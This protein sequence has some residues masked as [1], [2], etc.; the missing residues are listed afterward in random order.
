MAA[1]PPGGASYACPA[2]SAGPGV[3]AAVAVHPGWYATPVPSADAGGDVGVGRR[4]GHRVRGLP[5]AGSLGRG[6]G[7]GRGVPGVVCGAR[8]GC[9][10]SGHRAGSRHLRRPRRRRSRRHW[11]W[12]ARPFRRRPRPRPG[13]ARLR[14]PGPGLPSLTRTLRCRR[15]GRRRRPGRAG[16]RWSR[17]W[18]GGRRPPG[19]C[20]RRIRGDRAR[21]GDDRVVAGPGPVR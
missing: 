4:G 13:P 8:S 10:G 11:R 16:R 6:R 15:P 5:R 17:R 19:R 7:P 20:R 1:D 2:A 18:P 3:T 21:R 12:R 14:P 9:V